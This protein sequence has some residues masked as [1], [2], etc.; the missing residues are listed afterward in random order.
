M[1]TQVVDQETQ[2]AESV[3]LLEDSKA[4]CKM[5]EEKISLRTRQL[6]KVE[7][8]MGI[9]KVSWFSELNRLKLWK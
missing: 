2:L 3:M 5:H 6:D 1:K 9:L 7:T 4:N 8:A